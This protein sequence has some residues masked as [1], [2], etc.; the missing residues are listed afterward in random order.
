[1]VEP[2]KQTRRV[3]LTWKEP[4]LLPKRGLEQGKTQKEEKL[5]G[6]LKIMVFLN[7]STQG[8]YGTN[9]GIFSLYHQIASFLLYYPN[10]ENMQTYPNIIS[11]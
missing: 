8:H 9:L 11:L 4:S 10:S 1:M 6:L 2:L 7:S 5:I 3:R